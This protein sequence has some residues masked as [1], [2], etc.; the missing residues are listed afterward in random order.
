[1]VEHGEVEEVGVSTVF[2]GDHA[3]V[4]CGGAEQVR[5]RQLLEERFSQARSEPSREDHVE[6]HGRH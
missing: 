2:A 5:A 4:R 6:R 1:M 3:D